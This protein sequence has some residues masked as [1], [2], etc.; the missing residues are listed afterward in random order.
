V[1]RALAFA[2]VV[3][4][5]ASCSGR[6]R[7][8]GTVERWLVS[9]NQ[10]PAGEPGRYASRQLSDRVLPNW[11]T[12]DPGRM[13]VI[14][15]GRATPTCGVSGWFVPFR[16]VRQDGSTFRAL[17]CTDRGSIVELFGA[18]QAKAI[19]ALPSEGGPPIGSVGPTAW[20]LAAAVGVVL[21]GFSE[22]S[23][24]L[25]RRRPSWLPLRR[26]G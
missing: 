22:A 15:V 11:E 14:E 19:E 18:G 10:G 12:G 8:E 9:L 1:K 25:A 16:V 26:R 24:W 21:L 23:M 17:A 3:L 20:I 6:E 5:L 4:S 2:F 13:D 7:P